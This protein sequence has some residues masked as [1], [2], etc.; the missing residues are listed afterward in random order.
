MSRADIPALSII[1][2]TLNEAGRI[3][4]VL[5]ALGG[6]ENEIIIADGGSSDTTRDIAT[7]HNARIVVTPPGRGRQLVAGAGLACAPWLL[8][9][10]ADTRL[11]MGWRDAV[12][13]FRTAAENQHRAGVFAFRLDD[14]G[15]S[16]RRLERIV[17]WRNRRFGL[18][19][20]DQGLLISRA[21]YD[22]LGGFRT[23]PLMEDVDLVRRIGGRR[24]TVLGAHALTSADRYRRG[25]YIVRPLRNLACL[26]LFFLGLPPRAIN[27]IYR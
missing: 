8:F 2:P 16:A 6:D 22:Q 7:A 20:G 21:F 18:P 26:G 5:D 9:L 15:P 4:L 25:G 3:G 1:I 24:I 12:E 23:L 19:Y 27:W 17:A 10:H 14:D 13:N 11:S